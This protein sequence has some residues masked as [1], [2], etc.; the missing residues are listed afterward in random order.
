MSTGTIPF[1]VLER[2]LAVV[3]SYD[4]DLDAITLILL[5][6]WM[7][8]TAELDRDTAYL[9]LETLIVTAAEVARAALPAVKVDVVPLRRGA[10]LDGACSGS[11]RAEGALAASRAVQAVLNGDPAAGIDALLAAG[12]GESGPDRMVACVRYAVALVRSIVRLHAVAG[13]RAGADR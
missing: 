12:D 5:D 9:A 2:G 3:R 7:V 11:A 10:D 8:S 6:E 1:E 13:D 4:E